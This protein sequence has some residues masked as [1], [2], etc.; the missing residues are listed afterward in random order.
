MNQ[1]NQLYPVFD[2]IDPSWAD[3]KVTAELDGGTLLEMDD[4]ASV[5]GSSTVEVGTR[6]GASGGRTRGRTTGEKSDEFAW[7]LYRAGFNKLLDGLRQKAPKRGQQR[8]V[9]LVHFNIHTQHTP[10]GSDA[11]YEYIVRGARLLSWSMNHA[12]GVDADQV[13]CPL[14][15][16]EFAHL[17]NGEEIVLL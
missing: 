14:S 10:P 5:T 16:L 9:S 2:G 7:T 12:E 11:I 6:K 13:E 1:P 3:I 8:L 15:I 4:I 17:I